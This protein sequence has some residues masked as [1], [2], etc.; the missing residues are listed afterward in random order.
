[1]SVYRFG[2]CAWEGGKGGT[3]KPSSQSSH[4]ATFEIPTC[5]SIAESGHAS[6][7]SRPLVHCRKPT[8]VTAPYG[9]ITYNHQK[10]EMPFEWDNKDAFLAWLTAE[11]HENAIKFI[12]Q[13]MYQC[14]QGFLGGKQDHKAKTQIKRKIAPMKTGCQCR[15]TIKMYLHTD[16]ILGKYEGDHDHVL[17]NDNLRF[18]RLTERTKIS[19]MDMVCMGMDSKAILPLS[20]HGG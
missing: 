2:M 11:E 4:M 3:N 5:P 18:L 10:G 15:M 12:S 17:C 8:A 6:F 7:V 1:M 19:V 20:D 13:H 9:S 14:S 16:T